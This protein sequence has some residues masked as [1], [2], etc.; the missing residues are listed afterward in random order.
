MLEKIIENVINEMVPRSAVR[1]FEECPVH[2]FPWNGDP[3]AM[4]RHYTFRNGW[5]YS[6]DQDVCSQQEGY[7]Q[8]GQYVATVHQV[9]PK[10]A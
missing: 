5:R 4:H 3:G 9:N 2:S 10:H 1:T 7:Q 6:Q 8:T